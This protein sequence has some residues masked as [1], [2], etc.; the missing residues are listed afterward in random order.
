[1]ESSIVGRGEDCRG[2][3]SVRIGIV[4]IILA[5]FL[6][7]LIGAMSLPNQ[8]SSGERLGGELK[9]FHMNLGLTQ[10]DLA[11][12]Q[13]IGKRVRSFAA[14]AFQT[15]PTP[16][17]EYTPVDQFILTVSEQAVRENWKSL[18]VDVWVG[19]KTSPIGYYFRYE[20]L[21]STGSRVDGGAFLA[22]SAD[23]A[24]VYLDA[25]LSHSSRPDP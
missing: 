1:M 5:G 22:A 13:A 15:T 25:L 12:Q 24:K 2:V 23:L 14:S 10:T 20:A 8:V 17:K 4:R 3:G 16:S 7:G 6:L 9:I 19:G 11:A 21:D 18:S